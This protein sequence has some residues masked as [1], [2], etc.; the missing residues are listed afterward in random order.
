MHHDVAWYLY[1]TGR[2]LDG[3][4]LYRDI[5][6]LNPPLI[7]YL[8]TP[9]VWIARGLEYSSIPVFKVYV[10]LIAIFSFFLC[11]QIINK[12]YASF[13]DSVKHCILFVLL[14]VL[15]PFM[16]LASLEK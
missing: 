6:D 10:L 2:L 1:A 4:T 9:A 15:I 8:T 12:Y 3:A 5:I 11:R 7:F 13:S 14:L 16:G